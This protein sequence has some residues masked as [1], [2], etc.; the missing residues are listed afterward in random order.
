MKKVSFVFIALTIIV[1]VVFGYYYFR[2][3]HLWGMEKPI[4]MYRVEQNDDDTIRVL[5]LGDSWA[6][7]HY[8]MDSFLCSKIHEKISQPVIVVSQGK[9]GEK[10]RGIYRLL[11]DNDSL[12]MRKL[13]R[14][15]A[16][17]CVVFAGINDAAANLGTKQYCYHY[18][19]ILDFLLDIDIRPV[20][21][22]IPDVDIWHLYSGKKIKDFIAD[23][24]RSVMTGCKMYD[25][26]NYRESLYET[27]KENHYLDSVLYISSTLWNNKDM[28]IN[29]VLFLPDRIH[30]NKEGYKKLDERIADAIKKDIL[31]AN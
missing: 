14:S 24:S 18:M 29:P 31:F 25:M 7:M 9:G 5:L 12:G 13:I 28:T 4:P 11:F 26:S 17:Y 16:D 8:S 27:L 19:L 20:V 30:L 10:S 3:K 21:V 15:G 2:W 1:F 22:E 6:A 23:F